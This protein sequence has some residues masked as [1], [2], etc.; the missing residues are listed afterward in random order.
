MKI[1]QY[2][3]KPLF[4]KMLLKNKHNWNPIFNIVM[5]IKYIYNKKYNDGEKSFEKWLE[6]LNDKKY[7]DIFSCLQINQKDNFILIRYGLAE[8]QEGMWKD[9]NSIY[10]EC[11][12]I[13]IDLERDELVSTP[14]RKF[15]NLNE[16]KENELEIVKK[17][18]LNAKVFEITNKLDGSMQALRYYYDEYFMQGSIA[19]DE[20][21]SYRLQEGKSMLTD[22]M[23][24]MAKENDRYTF[25][26]EYISLKDV[27]VVIYDNNQQGLYLIGIRNVDTGE[28]LSYS[29]VKEYSIKYNVPLTDIENISLDE[30]FVQMKKLKSYEKEG[31]V[32]NIDSHLIK[33]KCDDYVHLHRILDKLGSVN[34]IIEALYKNNLDDIMSKLPIIYHD[35][36]K[37]I[38]NVFL[39]WRKRTLDE[40][41]KYYD[42]A[43]KA[44]RKEYFMWVNLNVPKEIQKYLA[45]KY[46]GKE[47]NLFSNDYGHYKKVKDMNL[48]KE[49]LKILYPEKDDE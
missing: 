1:L 14:F 41:N 12:S 11:R 25:I 46:L 36:I 32:L 3:N 10:R 49:E 39:N 23:K 4:L 27:H 16:V 31:W 33:I 26:F 42:L 35:R 13:V 21:D 5:E 22:N 43:P 18:I 2:W 30:L 29:Q 40:I 19:I 28:Q 15:F 45:K 6:K 7:N 37:N 8:M 34:V 20:N 17:E 9:E 44:N 38:V 47:I 24:L 48:T